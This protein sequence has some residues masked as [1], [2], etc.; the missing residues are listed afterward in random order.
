[1]FEGHII[2]YI[3]FFKIIYFERDRD[4]TSGGRAEIEG[5]RERIPSRLCAASAE[6]STELKLT[7]P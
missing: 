7:K 2:G 3:I 6:P 4:S 5:E 1:M